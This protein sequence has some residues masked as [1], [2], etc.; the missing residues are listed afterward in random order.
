MYDLTADPRRDR[1]AALHYGAPFPARPLPAPHHPPRAP[2]PAPAALLRAEGLRL[3]FETPRGRTEVLHGVDLAI[4]RGGAHGLVGE[5]GSG[6]SVTCLAMLGLLGPR[7]HLS[8]ALSFDGTDL[9]DLDTDRFGGLRGRRIAMIFQDPASALNP[10]LSIGRQLRDTLRL[11]RPL[12]RAAAD[13][14]AL[15]LLAL[16][17]IPAPRQRLDEYPHQLSGGMNQRVMIAL[18]LAGEPDLLIADEPTTALDVTIQAQILELLNDLRA[19][20][21]MTLVMITHDLAVVS[22]TCETVSVMYAGRVVEDGPADRVLAHPAHPY[23][24]ALLRAVPELEAPD[25]RLVP[26]PGQVPDPQSLGGGCAFRPRCARAG[27][28]CAGQ[29]PTLA[30][31]G[32][33]PGRRACFH[34]LRG[35]A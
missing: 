28:A 19:R 27:S 9:L 26:I 10:V 13:R 16:V 22:E 17:G 1:T 5:S 33:R 21:G 20:L 34:P 12:G 8:G 2:R 24:D 35:V 11:H 15:E 31:C 29:V 6:K 4:P 7:A 25:A 14:E 32:A 3:A 18:A 23:T 30:A